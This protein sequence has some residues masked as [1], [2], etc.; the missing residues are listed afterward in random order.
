MKRLGK[1]ALAFLVV[2]VVITLNAHCSH[3]PEVQSSADVFAVHVQE[4]SSMETTTKVIPYGPEGYISSFYYDSGLSDEYTLEEYKAAVDI[5]NGGDTKP[6][7]E[8]DTF[9]FPWVSER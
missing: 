4:L 9:I 2:T 1:I 6:P 7:V 5:V 8:G 3:K